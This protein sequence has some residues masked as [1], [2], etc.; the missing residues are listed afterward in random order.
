MFAVCVLRSRRIY[1]I[2]V[3]SEEAEGAC[4]EDGEA[5]RCAYGYQESIGVELADEGTSNELEELAI[6][7]P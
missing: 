7:I 1:D 5:E 6:C 3:W 4:D 2:V